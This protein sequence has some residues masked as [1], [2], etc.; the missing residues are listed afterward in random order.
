MTE[1]YLPASQYAIT[2]KSVINPK[3][4]QLKKC[5]QP[6]PNLPE[7]PLAYHHSHFIGHHLGFQSTAKKGYRITVALRILKKFFNIKTSSH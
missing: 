7:L 1:I 2:K 3:T 6:Q 4:A 5:V